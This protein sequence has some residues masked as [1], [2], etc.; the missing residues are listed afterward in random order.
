MIFSGRVLYHDR[1]FLFLQMHKLVLPLISLLALWSCA[2]TPGFK[3]QFALDEEFASQLVESGF[4]HTPL[5]LDYSRS[6]EAAGIAKRVTDEFAL[7]NLDVRWE[8]RGEGRISL[9]NNQISLVFSPFTGQ[10]AVGAPGDPDYA[11]YGTATAY[12]NLGGIKLEAWNRIRFRIFADC[13]GARVTNLNLVFNDSEPHLIN[14]LNGEWNECYLD[15]DNIDRTSVSGF[16]FSCSLKGIDMTAADS[17]RYTIADIRFQAVD[18]PKKNSGWMPEDGAIIYSTSGYDVNGPK[19]AI[20]SAGT[21]EEGLRFT[22]VDAASGRKRYSGRVRTEETTIGRYA[23]LDFSDFKSAG[24][25]RI[26]VGGLRTEDFYIDSRIWTDAQWKVLNYIFCQRCGYPVPG[27]HT[28]CHQDLFSR[29]NGQRISFSGGWHDAGDLSQQCLQTGDVTYSLL[30]AY[31]ANRESNPV[32][33]AR[34]LEEA[35]W[36]LEFGLKNRYGDGYRASSVGLVIWQDNRLET[37]DDI[38]SVR[39]HNLAYDNFTW[40]AY[41]A[42]AAMNLTGDPEMNT[43]LRK[44]A[45]EDFDFAMEKFKEDGWDRFIYQ[46]EHTYNS[47]PS[48][49]M[50]N[51]SWSASQLYKLTGDEKYARIAAEHIRYTLDC[52]QT[53]VLGDG[54]RGFFYRD[55]TRV[56]IV[57][58]I[59][60]SR[61]QLYIQALT[62]L[63]ETQKNHPDYG[64]WAESIKLY[65]DYLKYLMKYTAPYGMMP[66]GVYKEGEYNDRDGFYALHIFAASD[67]PQRFDNQLHNGV[68]IDDAHYI[69]RFPISF[70]IF[71]GNSAVMLATGKAAAIAGKFLGDEE[72]LDIAREQLYWNVGKNPFGESLIFGEGHNYPQMNS[73]S[74]GEITGEMPVGIKSLG[75]E[76]IPAWPQINNACYK[77][78]WLTTAGKFIS[79]VS[80]F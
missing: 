67:A 38:N 64:R 32:L 21:L 24:K 3:T 54:V 15:M 8:S 19:T 20:A 74:S 6:N 25:Y 78:V 79:L 46:Y 14:L 5:P 33:A 65:G 73:F 50:A 27:K 70:N 28:A 52:Q 37:I 31:L 12:C 56:G 43:Y 57:H 75:D 47:S 80:E 49:I 11:T 76:D 26:E 63:C 16:S 9:E 58:Y 59:H 17:L 53:E 2:K 42:F 41:E 71:S 13:P 35:R 39:V 45:C 60:Q 44:V 48:Q 36:G 66:S 10:R 55:T 68:R 7:D 4:I 18:S 69:R 29:H 1:N 62:L 40:A 23:V 34:M 72:L 77:E 61:E 22:V 51:I 30:E